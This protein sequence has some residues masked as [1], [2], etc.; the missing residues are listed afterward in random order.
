MRSEIKPRSRWD[1]ILDILE[2]IA[3]AE[4]RAKK[5][6]IM[7]KAY[8]DWRNFQRH[9]GFLIEGDFIEQIEDPSRGTVY[10]LTERGKDL[11]SKLKDV[12]AIVSV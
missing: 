9:F 6:R 12:G 8:L 10:G 11:K 4:N 3:I 5:T 7:K 1:I 2:V